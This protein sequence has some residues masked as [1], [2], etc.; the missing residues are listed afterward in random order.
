MHC[1]EKNVCGKDT[2][3]TYTN[4]KWTQHF[5]FNKDQPPPP[6]PYQILSRGDDWL[7][8]ET[9]D[10][11]GHVKFKI[12]FDSPDTAYFSV[13]YNDFI[14]NDYLKRINATQK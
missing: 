12:H 9:E 11:K 1:Y 7:E 3:F 2:V 4:K 10:S 13:N 5:T 6:M 8:I 14:Y